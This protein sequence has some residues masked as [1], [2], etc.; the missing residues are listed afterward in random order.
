MR[1][2][3]IIVAS[4]FLTGSFVAAQGCGGS[5][6]DDLPAGP[7][8]AGSGGSAGGKSGSGGS[9]AGMSQGGTAQ[10]GTA[11]GGTAQG[12]TAQGGKAQGGTSSGGKA[13]QA[14]GGKAGSGTA[15]AGGVD[16]FDASIPDVD[17]GD[18]QTAAGCYECTKVECKM[19]LDACAKDEKCSTA[20]SCVLTDCLDNPGLQC[21]GSCGF[22][23]GIGSLMDPAIGLV[24]AVAQCT[25][26]KCPND[27]PSFN[28]PGGTGGAGQGGGTSTGGS[29]GSG[30]GGAA[31]GGSTGTGGF[32][33]ATCQMN[34]QA[35]G[36]SCGGPALSCF[37]DGACMSCLSALQGGNA[38]DPS[39]AS[40]A[41]FKAV[42]D[43][44][45]TK[46]AQ[47]AGCCIPL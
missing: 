31:Q 21:I 9:T 46:P 23:A 29:A 39:C 20:A 1:K 32:S 2:T 47:C 3:P 7:T 42:V 6:T 26:S 24:T 13:G 11:Q 37:Q 10:G 4:L 34:I 41:K 30:T 43:C 12:G 27:C 19:E 17:I 18:G 40:N 36:A 16:L 8:V 33:A 5:T 14:Q 22:Q 38:P 28:L 15:G 44:A 35:C 25:G 45:C